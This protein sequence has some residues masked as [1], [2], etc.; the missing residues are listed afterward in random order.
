MV[1]LKFSKNLKPLSLLNVSQVKA[2]NLKL[3]I[4]IAGMGSDD[5]IDWASNAPKQTINKLYKI[6]NKNIYE[7]KQFPYIS[8]MRTPKY[9]RIDESALNKVFFQ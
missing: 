7:M 5:R 3:S 6:I 2:L 9:E 8:K 4:I 1:S